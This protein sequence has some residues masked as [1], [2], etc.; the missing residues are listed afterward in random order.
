MS[1][2]SQ[3]ESRPGNTRNRSRSWFLTYNN[4]EFSFVSLVSLFSGFGNGIVKFV[5]QRE[6]GESGTLHMQCVVQFRNQVEF[7]VL[8]A[9]DPG[10]HWERCKNLK[11]A[12]AYCTKSDT[13]VEGP[14]AVGWQLPEP[15]WCLERGAFSPWQQQLEGIV[16]GPIDPRAIYWLWEPNG[17]LGKTAFA[18]Y[19]A[20]R[21]SA[22]VLGGRAGDIKF[23]VQQWI[24]QHGK[25]QLAI[26]HFTRTNEAFTSYEAIEAVKDGIFYSGKYESGMCVFNSPTIVCFANY[27]PDQSRLSA[28]RWRIYYVLEERLVPDGENLHIE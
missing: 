7:G 25:L 15:I 12:L 11:A 28:D 8:K 19:C 13:R 27:R 2:M 16:T 17:G 22:L 10:I 23:G 20:L 18:K 14:W 21:L 9:V 5:G 26:F 24:K 4:C 3:E 6:R 1:H